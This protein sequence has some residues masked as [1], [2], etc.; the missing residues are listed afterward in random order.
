M[1]PIEAFWTRHT[2]RDEPFT[3]PKESLDYLEW[4]SGEY[5]LFHSLMGLWG[6]H[7][8]DTVLDF[9]CGPANDLVGFLVHG[10]AKRAI[11]VDVSA[12]SLALAGRRLALHGID[13]SRYS[14]IKASS[15]PR[16][17]VPSESV[18]YI[19][20]QGVLHHT[21][22][23]QAILSEFYRVLRHGG[24]AS[25]MVYNRDSLYLHL[26]VAYQLQIKD[27][28]FSDRTVD[29]AFRSSTDGQDCPVSIAF[30]PDEF[31]GMCRAAGF[32]SEYRG[33]YFSSLELDLWR[34][35]GTDAMDD[36]RLAV[37]HRVFLQSLKPGVF[38]MLN[39][40]PVGIGGVF[41]LCK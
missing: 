28:A 9:G 25:V 16:L 35:D 11:G 31:I 19:Y 14:L 24:S 29:E 32:T 15:D 38:P 39:S 18:D 7:A 4:R 26:Y 3:S 22:N 23:P 5:P 13:P 2:V 30:R 40:L 21:A 17:S 12:T 20:S 34:K 41:R 37:E 10:R 27:G 36:E 8:S 6:D 33:G 1:D